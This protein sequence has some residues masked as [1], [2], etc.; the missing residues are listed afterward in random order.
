MTLVGHADAATGIDPENRLDLLLEDDYFTGEL[1][2]APV[3]VKDTWTTGSVD[4]T[5][6][7]YG[8]LQIGSGA[9]RR[10]EWRDTVNT[11]AVILS[12][13]AEGTASTNIKSYWT[14]PAAGTADWRG[15]VGW[16]DNHVTFENDHILSITKYGSHINSNDD[17]FAAN[18]TAT[19]P[20]A[21]MTYASD[22]RPD[23]F[24]IE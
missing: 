5:N 14:S 4:T 6:F 19:E 22:K 18:P 8:M 13:R 12:D 11:E 1:M 7:S 15:S 3:D 23:F 24:P 20:D 9:N 2:I 16:N 17:L 21:T 10:A